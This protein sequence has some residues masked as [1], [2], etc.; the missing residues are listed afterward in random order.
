[1]KIFRVGGAV[2]DEVIGRKPK[3]IDFACEA[4]SFDDMRAHLLSEGFR[5]FVENEEFLTIRAKVPAGSE[6]LKLVND[7]DF[8]L[9]RKETTYGD[10]RHPDEV[11]PG[12]I[13][14]DLARRDFTMNALAV[15]VSTGETLDPFHGRADIERRVIRCV[16]DPWDRII[17]E[18]ALRGLRALRFV[19]ELE[20]TMDESIREILLSEQFADKLAMT[21]SEERIYQELE[22]TFKVDPVGA[23]E[24]FMDNTTPGLRR[25]IFGS[26]MWLK[27]SMTNRKT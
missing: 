4:K 21:V 26:R 6:L 27:P 25:V 10:G 24:R 13:L 1:M 20:F 3:D 12:T 14:Q 8:V 19:A 9:C 23:L 11:S 7:A 22:K 16:G 17:K 2:R 15:D 5:I 18:D